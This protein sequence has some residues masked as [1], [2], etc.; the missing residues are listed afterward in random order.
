MCCE[1]KNYYES[2]YRMVEMNHSEHV[3][4]ENLGWTRGVLS[5]GVPFEAEMWM[6]DGRLT[7]CVVLPEIFKKE[8]TED[9]NVV[10]VVERSRETSTFEQLDSGVLKMGTVERGFSEDYNVIISFVEYLEK[11]Q[12]V[13]FYGEYRNGAV[14]LLEDKEGNHLAGVIITL[15][16]N[17]DSWYSWVFFSVQMNVHWMRYN[18]YESKKSQRK[19]KD[20]ESFCNCYVQTNGQMIKWVGKMEIRNYQIFAVDFDGTLS[21]GQWPGIGP[22]NE[23]LFCFLKEIKK[24]GDKIILWTCRENDCL[25]EAVRWCKNLGL[26]FDAINCNLPEKI[27]EYGTDS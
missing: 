18:Q 12:M 20:G 2:L 7:L 26:E 3:G 11:L 5:D 1:E 15:K 14:H 4:S 16:G 13:E 8:E 19:T 10:E 23:E 9:K 6:R 27:I 17:G 21:F 22:A 25:E 24:Q